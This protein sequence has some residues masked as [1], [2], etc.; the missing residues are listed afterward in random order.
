MVNNPTKADPPE[1]IG[2]NQYENIKRA[3]EGLKKKAR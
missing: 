2:K 3:R 1:K